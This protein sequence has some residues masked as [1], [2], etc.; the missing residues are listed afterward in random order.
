M[1]KVGVVIQARTG[2]SRLANKVLLPFYEDQ[3]ILSIVADKFIHCGLKVVI[4]TTNNTND[5]VIEQFCQ[6]KKLFC[7]RGAEFDV[8]NRFISCAKS[9]G[10]TSLIRVCSDNPFLDLKEIDNLIK[11]IHVYK[12]A[13]YI[14][15][16]VNNLPSIKT[17]FGFWT[18][19]VTLNALE[20]VS[21]LT[22][23]K[24]YHEHVTNYIYMHPDLFNIVLLSTDAILSGEHNIR[25]TI[26]TKED[27]DNAREIYSKLASLG[28][29]CE[30]SAIINFMN[31]NVNLKER[32]ISE[33]AKNTK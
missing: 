32:M 12:N 31:D 11:N 23:D 30:L 28:G 25:L 1:N 27:F 6:S 26:D 33:I 2:S 3:T 5:D 9:F 8:L 22:N 14:S 20:K 24:L 10:F 21:K 19:Y 29:S 4:A 17:H 13:D 16:M 15:F 18:E 7:F